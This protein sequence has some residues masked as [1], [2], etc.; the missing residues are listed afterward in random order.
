MISCTLSVPTSCRSASSLFILLLAFR[1]QLPVPQ[2]T[3]PEKFPHW[4][5]GAAQHRQAGRDVAPHAGLGADLGTGAHLEVAGYAGLRR[6]GDELLQHRSDGNAGL[7][8][9]RRTGGASVWKNV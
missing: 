6:H 8:I 5:R 1:L 7:E 2:G 9:G 4:P 3:Q